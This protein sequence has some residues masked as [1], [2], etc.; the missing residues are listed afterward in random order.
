MLNRLLGIAPLLIAS[1]IV[2]L[3]VSGPLALAHGPTPHKT[4]ETLAIEAPPEAV[5][6]VLADFADMAAWHPMVTRSEGD[7][8]TANGTQRTIT[9]DSGGQLVDGLDEFDAAARSYTYRLARENL[10]VFPVSFYSAT[11]AVNPAGQGRS[12]V[13][14]T[15]RFYRGDT[16]NYPPESLN[17]AA[18]VAAMT[19]FLRTG[20]E[21][22]KQTVEAAP[23]D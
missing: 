8:G 23:T 13:V 2:P 11:I 20:L 14:W 19:Q 10:E 21:G 9:L 17:D 4:K 3:T 12:E 6:T 5:W 22:L 16:G 18:A 1:L 15:G 7:G